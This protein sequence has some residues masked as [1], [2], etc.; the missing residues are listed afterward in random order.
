M[1]QLCIFPVV[2]ASWACQQTLQVQS[3]CIANQNSFWIKIFHWMSKNYFPL[4]TS[5]CCHQ[6]GEDL[7]CSLTLSNKFGNQL[8][9]ACNLWEKR[10]KLFIS[11]LFG[12]C[13]KDCFR[14]KRSTRCFLA[15]L[16][17]VLWEAGESHFLFM[18]WGMLED[19]REGQEPGWKSFLSLSKTSKNISVPTTKA[20]FNGEGE[21]NEA[22]ILILKRKARL[23]KCLQQGVPGCGLDCC[24]GC[25]HWPLKHP[26]QFLGL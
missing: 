26:V 9:P 15:E 20:V 4:Y 24:C 19:Q 21:G 5:F 2:N 25:G 12:P 22:S 7:L 8:E 14:P 11:L 17:N 10:I 16:Q 13:H 6:R 3:L 18:N 1:G 23:L